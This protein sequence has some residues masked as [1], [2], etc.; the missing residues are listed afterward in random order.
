MLSMD[1]YMQ[2]PMM[3]EWVLDLI[4]FDEV[5]GLLLDATLQSTMIVFHCQN[6][7]LWLTVGTIDCS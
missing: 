7:I 5:V 4:C 6:G 1:E 3:S 2:I